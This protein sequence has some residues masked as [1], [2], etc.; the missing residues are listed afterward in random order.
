MMNIEKMARENGK[1]TYNGTEYVL[2]QQA[3]TNDGETYE[4]TAIRPDEL[5]KADEDGWVPCYRVT[6]Y[7]L[8]SY[9]PEEQ[10]ED[11][12]CDWSHADKV[13]STCEYNVEDG[14]IC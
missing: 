7:V 13:V 9:N 5:D 12:A 1:A 3:Y 2:L 6:W 10:E 14:Q 8:D 4:A 11:C